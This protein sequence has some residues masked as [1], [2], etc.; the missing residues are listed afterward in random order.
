MAIETENTIQIEQ[1]YLHPTGVV[2][3][4]TPE[5]SAQIAKATLN[6]NQFTPDMQ[7]SLR[8]LDEDPILRGRYPA[9]QDG[10]AY[11]KDVCFGWRKRLMSVAGQVSNCIV[12]EVMGMGKTRTTQTND[13]DYELADVAI[14]LYGSVAK[15]L[16][17]YNGH[18]DPSNIDLTVIGKFSSVERDELFDR[19]RPCRD[20]WSSEIGSN[21]GVHIQ[22]PERLT[23]GNY[24]G[25]LNYEASMTRALY[26]PFDIWKT[27]RREALEDYRERLNSKLLR[28]STRRIRG[29]MRRARSGEPKL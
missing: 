27:I 15:G 12:D 17:R 6:G 18:T 11:M 24:W 25:A 3:A 28:E 10:A 26:D 5:L 4:L 2:V 29:I 1:M 14:L 7:M 21:V 22:T 13:G 8:I 16:T 20:L 9:I 19:I 23:N